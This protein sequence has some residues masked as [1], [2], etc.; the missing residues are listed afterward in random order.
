MTRKAIIDK[1]GVV[2]NIIELA[3]DIVWEPPV[4]T[5]VIDALKAHRGDIYNKRTKKFTLGAP[6]LPRKTKPEEW[7]EASTQA[8]KMDLLAK[9][10]GFI[11]EEEP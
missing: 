10:L 11:V 6:I 3:T 2:L 4:G 1:D 9:R 5:T 8:A 7:A